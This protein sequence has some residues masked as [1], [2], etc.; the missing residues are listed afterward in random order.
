M[1]N[2][3]PGQILHMKVYQWSIEGSGINNRIRFPAQPRINAGKICN[4]CRRFRFNRPVK[5]PAD[6]GKCRSGTTM[7]W[8]T[9]LAAMSLSVDGFMR[10]TLGRRPESAS[11]KTP[12]MKSVKMDLRV[13][14]LIAVR[15]NLERTSGHE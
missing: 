11:G 14:L 7:C 3:H 12:F 5:N 8:V 9:R 2:L 15:N 13:K 10:S 1:D 6:R 4:L